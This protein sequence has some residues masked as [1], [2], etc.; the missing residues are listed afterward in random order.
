LSD[1]GITLE[2][3]LLN[4][5]G[6]DVGEVIKGDRILVTYSNENR[7]IKVTPQVASI[8]SQQS[9]LST[10]YKEDEHVR[11]TFVIEPNTADMHRII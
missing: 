3:T 9:F 11:I 7:G 4:V 8:R 6:E 2:S 5:E 10:Q 1:Y